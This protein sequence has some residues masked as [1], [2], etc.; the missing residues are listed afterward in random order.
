MSDEKQTKLVQ[1]PQDSAVAPKT[2]QGASPAT[3][4]NPENSSKSHPSKPSAQAQEAFQEFT[5]QL[6]SNISETR[7]E[8]EIELNRDF[9]EAAA[10]KERAKQELR[11]VVKDVTHPSRL[12]QE[13]IAEGKH[14]EAKARAI[15]H[16]LT[17]PR[18]ILDR[19]QV[20]A[21]KEVKKVE[22]EVERIDAHLR[23]P[24][25]QQKLPMSMKVYGWLCVL[26]GLAVAGTTI[27]ALVDSI[28]MFSHGGMANYGA[29]TVVVT[30]VHIA[31]IGLLAI[32]FIVFGCGQWGSV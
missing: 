12:V 18:E 30:F 14:I 23:D 17:H 19:A 24:I 13:G 2:S 11:D 31:V 32:M 20:S 22:A 16:D 6:N 3:G 4:N 21:E 15:S 10:D 27:K 8:W 9:E 5:Q 7:E 1:R 29:S 25:D 28:Q 26:C